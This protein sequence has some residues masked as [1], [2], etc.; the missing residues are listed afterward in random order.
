M[1]YS[2]DV[3]ANKFPALLEAIADSLREGD[4]LADELREAARK[5]RV[6]TSGKTEVVVVVFEG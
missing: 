3:R 4:P 1:K 2:V 5:R 6:P